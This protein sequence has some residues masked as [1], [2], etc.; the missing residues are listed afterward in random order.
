MSG[1]P[2]PRSGIARPSRLAAPGSISK[3][4]TS[5]S[6]VG[7][8]PREE[9]EGGL[10]NKRPKAMAPPP[11]PKFGVKKPAVSSTASR[12]PLTARN[13]LTLRN[14]N[15]SALNKTIATAQPSTEKVKGKL[16]RF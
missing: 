5:S 2:T 9:D 12:K 7:K 15:S 1:I 8:R 4:S 13:T 6:I 10:A 11:Q 14:T 3:A 16:F